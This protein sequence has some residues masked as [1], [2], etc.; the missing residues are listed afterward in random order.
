MPVSTKRRFLLLIPCLAAAGVLGVL[1]GPQTRVSAA[2]DDDIGKSVKDFTSLYSTVENNF[3]D[4]VSADKAIYDGAIPGMLRTLDPHSNF[5]DPKALRAMQEEQRGRYYGIGMQVLGRTIGGVMTTVVV[6]TFVGSPAYKAGL[7]PND[8]IVEVDNKST[9]GMNSTEVADMLKG[10]R[11]TPVEVKVVR[12]ES[13]EKLTF[14]LI[15]DEISRSSVTEA[16]MVQPGIGYIKLEE[17]IETTGEDFD[18]ALKNLDES[19]L[20]GL[21][22]D[23]RGNPGG[24]LTEAVSVA[25]HLLPKG[26]VIVSHHGRASQERVYKATEGNHGMKYPIVV[27][28]NRNSA[29]ASEIVSGSLQDHDRAWIFGDN[30]FGKGLVQTVYPLA[31]NTALALTTAKYYTPSGRLIQRDYSSVSFFDYYYRTN[32]AARNTADMKTTDSGRTVYGGGGI[33]PDEKYEVPPPGSLETEL[34]LQYMIPTYSKHFFSLNKEQLAKGWTVDAARMDDFKNWLKAQKFEFTDADFTKEYEPI[35]RAIQEDIYRTAFDN[36]V[37][38]EYHFETDPE[39][40]AAVAAM[41]RA[42]TLLMMSGKAQR[43]QK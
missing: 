1:L 29:S 32:T 14:N 37:A 41:P 35:R 28:V 16:F 9:I 26:D 10:P 34:T 43:A 20:K 21:V 27:I 8:S 18:A 4:P 17:F 19:Q 42:E 24:L 2:S 6:S 12:G 36:N 23:L 22:L 31:E 11:G 38:S 13:T 40:V 15:R 3:A 25:G 33:S 7:R 39:V 5:F 30:T